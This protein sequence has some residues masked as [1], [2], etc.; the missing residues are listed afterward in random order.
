MIAIGLLLFVLSAL[1]TAGIALFNSEPSNASAFGVTL[2]NVSIGGLFIT[3]VITGLVGMLGLVLLL[4]G[5]ARKRQRTRT[6][7]RAASS[8]R[9]AAATLTEENSRLQ[10][11]LDGGSVSSPGPA[12][13]AGSSDESGDRPVAP[14]SAGAAGSGS[15]EATGPNRGPA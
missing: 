9:T 1:V 2:S 3:G 6:A 11:Q 4:A 8:A 13:S 5:T 12:I 10:G 15:G 14:G 7:K